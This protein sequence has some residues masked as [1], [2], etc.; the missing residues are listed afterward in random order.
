MHDRKQKPGEA[1][2]SYAQDLKCLFYKAYPLAQQA[3]ANWLG[4]RAILNSYSHSRD[5]R[6]PRFAIYV[7]P[8]GTRGPLQH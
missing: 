2:D 5:L 3:N 7:K 1:V 8:A 6:R 4:R